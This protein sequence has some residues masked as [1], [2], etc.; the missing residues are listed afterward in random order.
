MMI[1]SEPLSFPKGV[2]FACPEEIPSCTD[3]VLER[4]RNARITTGWCEREGEEGRFRAYIEANVH[5]TALWAVFEALAEN[6]LP[7]V[8]VPIIGWNDPD[9][10]MGPSTD[11]ASAL[12]T[13][14]PHAE[15]L[16][17][18]GSLEF[19]LIFQSRGLIEEIFVG[20][21]KYLQIWTNDDQAAKAVLDSF[22]IL[23]EE[24][25][26][27]LDEYPRVT[28]P[29]ADLP[30]TEEVILSIRSAFGSLPQLNS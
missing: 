16:Q 19:G 28:E 21:T 18:D 1:H 14:R 4:I 20:P 26:A 7:D 12:A 9:P 5:A 8:A 23:K 13:L 25:L 30:T 24:N 11:K 22:G 10:V 15:S 3:E 6:L 27:F 29:V 2:R 17:H